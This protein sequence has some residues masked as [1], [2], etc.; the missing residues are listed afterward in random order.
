MALLKGK[1]I[2]DASITK[3][4]LNLVTPTLT[5]D[6][7]TKDYVDTL[8]AQS[9][10]NQ[11]WKNSCR[12][13]STG[14]ITIATAPATIDGVTLSN[15]DRVLLKNQTTASQNGIY[16]FN[17][18]G[19]AMTRST[20]ADSS[21][22]VTPQMA[23]SVEEGT[24]NA[25]TSWRLSNTGVIVVGTTSLTFQLFFSVTSPV[26]KTQNK[27]MTA[28]VTSADF[29]LACAASIALTPANGGYVMVMVNGNQETLGDGV[30]TRSCYFSAD[31]GTTAKAIASIVAGDLLYW[32]GSVA[33][34]QLDATDII[35]FNY[36]A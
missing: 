36:Q 12:V 10:S 7:A 8:V 15:G 18:S 13:A 31:S 23:V 1:Q 26:L 6:P 25:S 2:Q 19:S 35:D 30:K 28:S 3:Q 29:S 33:G 34:Y 4:K 20:D 9:I 32:V 16:I 21:S 22:E 11:D 27:N 17:G 14:N 24:A 5:N